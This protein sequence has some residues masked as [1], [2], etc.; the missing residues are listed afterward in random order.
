M[1]PSTSVHQPRPCIE[2]GAY[3]KSVVISDYNE[4][5]EYFKDGFN[6]IVFAPGNSKE[7]V[8]KIKKLYNNRDLLK[9]LG[10]HNRIMT[11]TKH[12]FYSCKDIIT[13]HIQKNVYEDKN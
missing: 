2:A 3:G 11:E 1:F 5:G 10:E 4:T 12:N 8:E 13:T 9:E 6:A 7:L